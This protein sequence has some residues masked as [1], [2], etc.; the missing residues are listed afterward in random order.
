M[1]LVKRIAMSILKIAWG[2]MKRVR[3][4]WLCVDWSFAVL[5]VASTEGTI[6]DRLVS[7]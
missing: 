7:Q 2:I 1:I 3:R 5:A 4:D 6:S